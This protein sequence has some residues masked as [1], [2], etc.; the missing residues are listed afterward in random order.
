M[1]NLKDIQ[2]LTDF[3]QRTS[4]YI[5]RIK[6]TKTPLVLTINGR[7]EIV[8][9]DAESYQQLMERIAKAEAPQRNLSSSQIL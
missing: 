8:V 1:F 7:A 6:E 4:E 5:K 3:K 9:Q 2:S